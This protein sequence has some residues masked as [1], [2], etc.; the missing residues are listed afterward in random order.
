M[1]EPVNV[2]KTTNT[3]MTTNE[4]KTKINDILKNEKYIAVHYRGRDKSAAGGVTKKIHEIKSL[5]NKT[6]I[7]N[8]FVATDNCNFFK[9]LEDELDKS[10]F[11]FRYTSPPKE[12]KNIH[13]NTTTFTK[14]ENLYKTVLDIYTCR[15]ATHF[16]PSIN[17][18][19]SKLVK[20]LK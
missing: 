7:K 11:I 13:Y 19:F 8:I 2:S 14:G 15:K 4:Q 17:S 5:I 1:L 18:G 10:I 3:T 9:F 16:I 6:K 20:E 12:G